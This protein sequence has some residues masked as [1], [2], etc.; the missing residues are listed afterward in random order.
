[1]DLMD[2]LTFI[3]KRKKKKEININEWH[4]DI[5]KKKKEWSEDRLSI[6]NFLDNF[7]IGIEKLIN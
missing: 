7:M 2:G 5:Q 6:Y 1:M 3:L 4:E